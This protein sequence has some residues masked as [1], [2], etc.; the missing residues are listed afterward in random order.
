MSKIVS[1]ELIH[2]DV[3]KK[4]NK[5][6]KKW[7]TSQCMYVN[8]CLFVCSQVFIDMAWMMINWHMLLLWGKPHQT[9]VS[10]ELMSDNSVIP[11]SGLKSAAVSPVFVWAGYLVQ[12]LH[13]RKEPD[14]RAS[15]TVYAGV[16]KESYLQVMP[17]HQ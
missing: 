7:A 5:R 15:H 14:R 12:C 6:A 17:L 3:Q 4:I 10:F 9:F 16:R 1:G 2:S 8:I 13:C 11:I